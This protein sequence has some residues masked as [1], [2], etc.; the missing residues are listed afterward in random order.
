MRKMRNDLILGSKPSIPIPQC[1]YQDTESSH[2]LGSSPPG[3]FGFEMLRFMEGN[4]AVCRSRRRR[5]SRGT[6]SEPQLH[7]ALDCRT[8]EAFQPF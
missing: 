5:S 1:A 2:A 6:L 4:V 7:I 8:L 3:S